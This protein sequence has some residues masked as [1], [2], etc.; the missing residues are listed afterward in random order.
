MQIVARHYQ[1]REPVT[2][3]VVGD[4]IGDVL[5]AEAAD[6]MPWVAPGL[7]DPQIN[8][9]GGIWFSSETLTPHQVLDALKPHFGFGL[10]RLFPTLITASPEALK[11]GV[12]SIRRACEMEPWAN[13]L[14]AGI[15]LEGP[16]ISDEDGPR[17]AHPREH[18]RPPDWEEFSGLQQASGNRVRLVTLAPELPGSMEFIHRAVDCAV[19]IAIGHT[20]ATTAQIQAAVHAGAT[21]STHLGNGMHSII[22]R[23]PNYLWDQLAEPELA[24]SVIPDGFHLPDSVLS[25]ILRIK[26]P[27]KTIITC[28]A[29]GLA[30]CPPGDYSIHGVAVVVEDT[31]RIYLADTPELLAGSAAS[32]LDCVNYLI[33]AGLCDLP[34]AIEMAGITAAELLGLPTAS[35][36]RGQRAD[37]IL[38]ETGDAGEIDLLATVAAGAVRY[39]RE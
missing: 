1:T 15:H 26:G 36:Q 9:H 20:A 21:M 6:T 28:D 27:Q 18:I 38:F 16:S 23:H 19:T 37:F 25:C 34:A 7:F 29:A 33:C 35:L 10:T 30:G 11:N 12:T 4:L 3:S 32:T 31:G 5:P 17:G 22:P 2:V 24:A 13:E 8:G 14:V 39:T